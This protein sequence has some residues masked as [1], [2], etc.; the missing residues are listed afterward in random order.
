MKYVSTLIT[1]LCLA[2]SANAQSDTTRIKELLN[3][4]TKTPKPRNHQN[5]DQLNKTANL[6]KNEFGKYL[7]SVYFQEYKVNGITYKNVVGVINPRG[8]STLVLGAHYDVC[9]NQ[10]GADD[11]GSVIVGLLELARLF[12]TVSIEK[13]LEFVAYTLEEPPYFRSENMGSYVHAK[14]LSD[15]NRVVEGM[16]VLEMIGYFSDEKKSQDYPLGVLKM[17]YGG[18]GDYITVVNKFGKGK[19]ARRFLHKMKKNEESPEVKS[20]NAPKSL[21]GIDFSDHLNYWKFGFSAS[22]VTDTAFYRNKNY[23]MSTDKMEL[24]DLARMAGVID[25]VYKSLLVL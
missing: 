25:C 20:F 9:G 7:D 1:F 17:F 3:Q 14:S 24:L 16:I 23:H 15:E 13:R 12:D 19:F 18:K 10:E 22:M 6:I 2:L 11:N 5:P 4:I 21:P 8:K